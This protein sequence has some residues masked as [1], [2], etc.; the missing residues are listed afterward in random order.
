[1]FRKRHQLPYAVHAVLA[2]VAVLVAAMFLPAA[3]HA[4]QGAVH[5]FVG[6]KFL[7][8][9]DWEPIDTQFELGIDAAL[10][11]D[12]WPIWINLGLFSASDEEELDI[13]EEV[14]A[15][16]TE[17]SLG[18]NKT[19]TRRQFRP[20]VAGGLAFVNTDIEIRDPDEVF[21]DDDSGV[22][23]YAQGGGYWRIGSSF[24]LGG[25][26]RYSVFS[27]DFEGGGVHVGL[28]AGFGWPKA[29]Y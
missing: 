22:G 1:M 15:T 19:W 28:I 20:F 7:D 17:F 6:Q 29:R 18:I 25:M 4:S 9:E 5:V 3:A 10:G 16:T 24:N 13:D 2:A 23:L 26:L 8:E 11:G 12:D 27:D 14:E 21:E